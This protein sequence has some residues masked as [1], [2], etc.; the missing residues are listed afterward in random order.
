MTAR[1]GEQALRNQP[2][3]AVGRPPDEP[4][5]GSAVA[6]LV[7]DLGLA[8]TSHAVPRNPRKRRADEGSE[9]LS[10]SSKGRDSKNDR[11]SKNEEPAKNLR[12]LI[13]NAAKSIV[14]QTSRKCTLRLGQEDTAK[15]RINEDKKTLRRK[16][17]DSVKQSQTAETNVSK[18]VELLSSVEIGS[19]VEDSRKV[20]SP[21]RTECTGCSDDFPEAQIIRLFC[22]PAGTKH[23]YCESCLTSIFKHAVADTDRLPPRCCEPL[24]VSQYTRFLPEDLVRKLE[25]KKEEF[26]TPNRIYCSNAK[27]ARWI[28]PTNM[29]AG[30]ATCSKCS[31]KTCVR[32]KTK[33]HEGL[34]SKD[35]GVQALMSLAKK[36]KWQSCP[37]C[38]N[39][40]ELSMGCYHIT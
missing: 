9:T 27:C 40:V 6:A 34:C 20:D 31:Q 30:V 8:Q 12:D 24:E 28:K 25:D 32:C 15:S 36:R 21:S 16:A 33:H 17:D 26:D 18:E 13:D 2:V 7:V 10:D 29:T 5:N 35:R 1:L 39:M 14:Q 3:L 38:K 19:D 23:A 37:Q 22:P 11:S 4:L